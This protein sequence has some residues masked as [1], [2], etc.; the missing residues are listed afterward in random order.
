[1]DCEPL[2]ELLDTA[3]LWT[4]SERL[5]ESTMPHCE[6]CNCYIGA[7]SALVHHLEEVHNIHVR[8]GTDSHLAYCEDCHTYCGKGPFNESRKALEKHLRNKHCVDI[9]G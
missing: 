4:K 7:N 8:M 2:R 1:M 9:Q 5:I 3:A 6:N